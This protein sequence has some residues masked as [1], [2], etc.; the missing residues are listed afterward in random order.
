MLE[1]KILLFYLFTPLDDPEAIREWQRVL[2]ESLGLVGRII[3]SPHGINGT[4]GGV[5]G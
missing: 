3:I 5:Y 1:P 2:C 4:V